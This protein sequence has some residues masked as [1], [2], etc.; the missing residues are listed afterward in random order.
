M[1]HMFSD[2]AGKTVLVTGAS[3]GIGAATALALGRVGAKVVLAA[4]RE[5]PCHALADT[6]VTSGGQALVVQ[7]DVTQEDAVRRAVDA[8]VTHFGRLDG[9]FNNAGALGPHGDLH[10][11]PSD[12]LA[13]TLHTNVTASFWCMK[14]QIEAMLKTGGGAIVNNASVSAHIGFAGIA[15]YNASKHALL[16]LTRTAA[17]EY[18]KKGIRIN[19]VSPGPVATDMA[20]QGF[21]SSENLHAAMATSPAGRAG[22]PD[23]IAYP[24]LFLLSGAASFI[25]GHSLVVDG[26]F[27]V[28]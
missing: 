27:T 2:L 10:T 20:Y 19:L 18:F 9:A 8:A 1:T 28:Q 12:A 15:P 3:S 14:Y 13:A 4:R 7:T 23:E 24:V 21:G 11:L 17:L 22:T 26:G 25:S 6:I 16:G 5:A